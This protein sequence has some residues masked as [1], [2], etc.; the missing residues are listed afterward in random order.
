MLRMRGKN[1]T[2]QILAVVGPT[3]IGKTSLAIALARHFGAPVLS[4]DSR[5]F[6]REM[7][8]GTAAPTPAEQKRAR[9]FFV[10]HI[11]IHQPYDAGTY[12]Q[13]ALDLIVHLQTKHPVLILCGGSG[14]Y[15]DAV[16][17]GLNEFP[18]VPEEIRQRWVET[19]RQRGLEVLQRELLR[20]DPVYYRQV[21][22]QNPHRLIRALSVTEASGRPYSHFLK[23]PRSV[24]PFTYRYVRIEAPRQIIYQ[25]IEQRVDAMMERGLLAEAESLYPYRHLNALQ[26]VGYREIFAYM[27]GRYTLDQAVEEIKKN[28]RRYAKRQLTWL[29]HSDP[30]TLVNW[31]RDPREVASEISAKLV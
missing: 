29:R 17:R 22:R 5:Q 15:V 25:R 19:G 11:G 13:D 4:A 1:V 7:S 26:T 18:D 6:Y 27:E 8:I 23:S 12:Q 21:D 2:P 30:A 20:R 31:E 28:T 10:H 9:H 16:L 3:A 24:R 14:L